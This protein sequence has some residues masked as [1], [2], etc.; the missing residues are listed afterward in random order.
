MLWNVFL[1]EQKKKKSPCAAGKSAALSCQHGPQ[2]QKNS[3]QHLVASIS[4]GLK[5]RGSSESKAFSQYESVPNKVAD[6]CLLCLGKILKCN[7]CLQF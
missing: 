6:E 1:V 5:N 2:S 3:F 7:P 4:L